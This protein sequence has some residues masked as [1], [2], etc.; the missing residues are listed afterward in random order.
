MTTHIKS[1]FDVISPAYELPPEP[2]PTKVIKTYFADSKK[3]EIAVDRKTK[4]AK[5]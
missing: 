1:L 5:K 4:G 2:L 3:F